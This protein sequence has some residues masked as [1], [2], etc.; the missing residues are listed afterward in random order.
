MNACLEVV[1]F[2]LKPEVSIDHFWETANQM[3]DVLP[4]LPG[5]QERHLAYDADTM[6][7][8]DVVHWTSLHEAH[9]AAEKVKTIEACTRMF[10]LI[11]G[12]SVE[13]RHYERQ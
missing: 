12:S 1:T 5:Y 9:E 10:R 2:K 6:T 3:T 8:I 11:D 7:W 13:L 4:Q